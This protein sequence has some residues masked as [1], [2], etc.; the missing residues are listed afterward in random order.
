MQR[1]FRFSFQ[2]F[3]QGA[4]VSA[5]PRSHDEYTVGWICA[6]P[7][8]LT[9]ARAMLDDI[10]PSLPIPAADENEYTLGSIGDHNVVITCLPKY[11]IGTNPTARAAAQMLCT[12]P[13]KIGL[14]VGVG[15][16]IPSK[17]SLGD[18]V[19]GTERVQWDFGRV[20]QGGFERTS[21][22]NKPPDRLLTAISKLKVLREMDRAR[23]RG[24]RLPN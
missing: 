4:R 20:V 3:V 19:V 14:L 16:G 5:N 13:I 8:E 2:A 24:E 9:A 17:V 6:L 21:Q 18:V 7:T 12:F 10:H 22:R 15:G 23:G 1:G 11:S